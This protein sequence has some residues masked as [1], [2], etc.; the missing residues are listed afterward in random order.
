VTKKVY[1][2]TYLGHKLY[3]A[4]SQEYPYHM[5]KRFYL[6]IRKTADAWCSK[7]VPV[8]V[9]AVSEDTLRLRLLEDSTTR[10]SM[11]FVTLP[12][13]EVI[14]Q[15]GEEFEM[16]N[17]FDGKSA[18]EYLE[19]LGSEYVILVPMKDHTGKNGYVGELSYIE[20]R[21]SEKTPQLVLLE[22]LLGYKIK[23]A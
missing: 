7:S 1:W 16:R 6:S 11:G 8:A 3:K 20:P 21:T 5:E 19:V 14:A 22:S 10:S 18:K 2:L 15:A 17:T 23:T 12:G 4:Y 13:L 9:V